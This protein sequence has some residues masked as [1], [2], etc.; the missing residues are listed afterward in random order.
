M[1]VMI[2][3]VGYT[4]PASLEVWCAQL[5][6]SALTAHGLVEAITFALMVVRCRSSTASASLL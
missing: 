4:T 5:P 3:T 1:L 2:F 6:S